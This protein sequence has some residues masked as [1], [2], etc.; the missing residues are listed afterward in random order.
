MG[1]AL[2]VVADP[3]L[4]GFTAQLTK[5]TGY[6]IL[7][8]FGL[9]IVLYMTYQ[10]RAGEVESL[11]RTGVE[12]KS[13]P[14]SQPSSQESDL[15]IPAPNTVDPTPSL[16]PSPVIPGEPIPESNSESNQSQ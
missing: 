11:Q 4:G 12:M 9:A 10:M 2:G 13:D 7:G 3:V 16:P 5:L 14:I 1:S 6:G 8:F 15:P